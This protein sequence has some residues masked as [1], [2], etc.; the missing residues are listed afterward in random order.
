MHIAF[1]VKFPFGEHIINMS[2][3]NG[4]IFLKQFSHLR[5][6]EPNGLFLQM[7]LKLHIFIGL[8]QYDFTSLLHII[9]ILISNSSQSG[10]KGNFSLNRCS[11]S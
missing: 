4:S 5:L 2:C 8:I 11:F 1:L 3:Y 9:Y 10:P 6:S 7:Y